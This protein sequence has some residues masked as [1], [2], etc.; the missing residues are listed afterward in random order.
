MKK[1]IVSQLVPALLCAVAVLASA[2][3]ARAQLAWDPD[4]QSAVGQARATG[5]PL[6]IDVCA[7]WCEWCKKLDSDVYPEV[8]VQQLAQRFVVAKMD[9]EDPRN[10][11]FKQEFGVTGYPTL[12]F[13]DVKDNKIL[14]EI[15]G[16][17][18]A[19]D[20]CQIMSQTLDIRDALNNQTLDAGQLRGYSS[21]A[22]YSSVFGAPAE[23]A[24]GPEPAPAAPMDGA[25]QD[26][27]TPQAPSLS[28][29]RYESTGQLVAHNR[30]LLAHQPVP[31]AQDGVY[32]LDDSGTTRLDKPATPAPAPAKPA[33]VKLAAGKPAPAKSGSAVKA[34]TPAPAAAQ[35]ASAPPS[36]TAT[37]AWSAE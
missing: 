12:L 26:Q 16:Y 7:S 18:E 20:L 1:T 10:Q 37:S 21:Q 28:G 31:S 24:Q 35:A 27:S 6:M 29:L 17:I 13:L 8:H 4:M 23:A 33:V 25:R 5:K 15:P 11:G 34:A 30:A 36:N 3:P 19:P 9:G 2:R 14:N 32:L 22:L